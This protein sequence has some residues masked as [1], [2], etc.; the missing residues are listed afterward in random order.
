[1]NLRIQTDG[2]SKGN[3]GPAA[4]GIVIY[5][6][7]VETYTFRRDIGIATNNDAEYQALIAA[8]SF[9]IEHKGEL[10]NVEKIDCR[11]DSQLVVSQVRGLWKVKEARIREYILKIRN[12]EG[13]IN[14]PITYTYVPREQNTVADA[15][16]NNVHPTTH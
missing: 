13:E 14:L 10:K 1:M 8:L 12:L 6:D 7:G 3:P 5:V 9:V 11:A 4:I 15:L 2:G 16:V